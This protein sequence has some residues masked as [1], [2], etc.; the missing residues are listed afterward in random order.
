MR[1]FCSFSARGW[2]SSGSSTA[3]PGPNLSTMDSGSRDKDRNSAD[4]WSLFGPRPLQKPD[5]G[6]AAPSKG[7]AAW[8]AFPRVYGELSLILKSFALVYSCS[9]FGRPALQRGPE[10][11]PNGADPHSAHSDGRIM[12]VP[13]M[14]EDP[15]AFKLPRWTSK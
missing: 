6:K 15:T 11:F 14:G 13:W 4:K 9:R 12:Q 10:T 1:P 8:Q 7:K 5:S 2:F 3:L